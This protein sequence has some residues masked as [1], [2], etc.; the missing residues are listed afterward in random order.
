MAKKIKT[1]EE[2][3]KVLDQISHVLLRPNTYVGS[4]KPNTSKKWILEDGEIVQKEVTFVPSFLKIFDEVITN[5]VDEAKREGS[6]LNTIKI[7]IEK[8]RIAVYDNGG[9]PVVIH[10]EHNSYLPEVIFGNLLAGRNFDDEEDRIVAGTN[11]LGAKLTNIFSKEFIVSTC[12]GKN[13]FTQVYSNNMSERTKPAIKKS[14]KAY[15]EISFEPDYSR[16]GLTEIDYDHYKMIEKRIYDIAACNPKLK[17]Y[18]ND[19]LVDINSFEDYIKLYVSEYFYETNKDKSWSLGIAL[20]ENGFQQISFSN[21]TETYDGGTHVDYIMNQ[22]IVELREYFMK[23]HKVDVKPNELKNH[24]FLFLDSTVINPA[25][26]SQT[27]EKLITEIKDFGTTY[28]VSKKT[29]QS[30]LKSEIVNS[31]LDWIEQ[32]KNAENNKLIRKLTKSK[33]K[34]DKLID[35]QSN[36][37]NS[38]ELFIMEGLSALGDFRKYRDADTQAA[39]SLRGKFTN[40]TGMTNSKILENEEARNL[41][42]SIGLN[43]TDVN[44]LSNL[45]F[46]KIIICTD[47]DTDGDSI[48]AQ[49]L[50]FFSKWPGLIESGIVHRA[51]APIMVVKAKTKTANK[52]YFYTLEEYEKWVNSNNVNNFEIDYKKGLGSL[53]TEEFKELIQETKLIKFT[54]ND[55]DELMIWF[56]DESLLRKNKLLEIDENRK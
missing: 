52:K 56:G 8:N 27:K 11:G 26:S 35:C 41:I 38:C 39:Y 13:Q 15:T 6:K 25:F 44:D 14:T 20:S 28:E 45:R 46:G 36:K 19:T 3:Y 53:E 17:I 4:N 1:I 34:V 37:R 22:I 50:N 40:I 42:L 54:D 16:F 24:M 51:L 49:L 7:K 30:I 31:V 43:I 33:V 32:K 55:D 23:K 2:K 12:D 18:F 5:S 29:I 9:I 10:K 48:C 21:S 47:L